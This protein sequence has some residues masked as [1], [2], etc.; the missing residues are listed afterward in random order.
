MDMIIARTPFRVS[1]FGGGTDYPEWFCRNGGAV[2]ATTIDKY[3]YVTC[4]YLPPF[5]AH[6]SRIAYSTIE[7]VADNREIRHPAVRHVLQYLGVE[8]GV[9]IHYDADLPARTGLGT[10][11]SFVVAMLHSVYALQRRMRTNAELARDAVHL[12]QSVMKENVGCQDQIL[13]AHG[14]LNVVTFDRGGRYQI[15]PIVLDRAR[16]DALESHLMLCFTGISRFSSEVAREQV[17]M[18]DKRERE[19]SLM[20]AM[21]QEGLDV[22]SSAG[23]I[24]DFGRLLHEA[25]ML[26]KSLASKVSLPKIDEIYD[27]A[28][29]AGAI[30]GKVLGAGGGGFVL[31]FVPPEKQAALGERLKDLLF[32]PFK[33]E[34]HGSQIIYY[35]PDEHTDGQGAPIVELAHAGAAS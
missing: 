30:G 29:K 22:L 14:G 26:K 8:R 32:V 10:S 17:K 1:F 12:E 2:L 34:S 3:C 24:E 6:R 16:C 18:M 13:T 9:E 21:V 5:F 27:A 11:S 15:R 19:L 4:R 35:A 23:P 33:M 7:T 31:L 28:R 20:Q 25:W